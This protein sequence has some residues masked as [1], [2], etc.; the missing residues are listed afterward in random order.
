MLQNTKIPPQIVR[1]G[2]VDVNGMC[3]SALS[4]VTLYSLH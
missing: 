3:N 4:A 2:R 1:K